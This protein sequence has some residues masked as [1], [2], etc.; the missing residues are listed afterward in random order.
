MAERSGPSRTHTTPS[1]PVHADQT[2]KE[3][4]LYSLRVLKISRSAHRTQGSG[5]GCG[6]RD[7]VPWTVSGRGRTTVEGDTLGPGDGPSN[8]GQ[9]SSPVPRSLPP[10]PSSA[11]SSPTP[12]ALSTGE[13]PC[14]VQGEEIPPRG[15]RVSG[16]WVS[17]WT[18]SREYSRKGWAER[19]R[20]HA[21][22]KARRSPQGS[23]SLGSMGVTG[24][25]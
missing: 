23:P 13:E 15:L 22:C 10:V 16:Q 6:F 24:D 21:R 1:P 12:D 11:K 20:N 3:G 2:P 18:S 17:L 9:V 4:T 8:E 25:E 7:R 19:V 5:L 14:K